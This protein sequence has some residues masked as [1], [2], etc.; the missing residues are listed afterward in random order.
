MGKKIT[1]L[2]TRHELANHLEDM[3]A[4]LRLGS[5]P[6]GSETLEVPENIEVRSSIK[7]KRHAVAYKLEWRWAPPE[8]S[9][10]TASQ[11]D[12]GRLPS[13]FKQVKKDLARAFR[14]IKQAVSEGLTPDDRLLSEFD[15]LSRAFAA[16]ADPEWERAARE[17]LGHMENLFRSIRDGRHEA[18]VHEIHDLQTRM[19]A[20]HKE[21]R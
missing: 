11:S 14:A 9:R 7:E 16:Q 21:L 6:F 1:T 8:G 18:A 19:V 4:Q 3:A 10:V 17:Y 15:S 12:V 2:N 13:S 20:C 5:I